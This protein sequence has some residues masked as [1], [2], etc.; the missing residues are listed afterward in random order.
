MNIDLVSIIV[1]VYNAEKYLKECIECLINQ[2]Y[3][4]IE[5][6]C[7]ND[8]SKDNSLEILEEYSKK[9]NRVKVYSQENKGEAATRNR[10][11]ELATG[12][13][14]T[15]VD[16]D[17]TCSLNSIE[18]CINIAKKTDS[19]VIAHFLNIRQNQINTPVNQISYLGATQLFV[20]KEL[21]DEHPDIRYNPKIKMGPDAV[22]SH[23]ILAVAKNISKN[24]DSVYFYRKHDE[25]ISGKIEN[26]TDKLLE[27]IKIWFEDLIDFYNQRDFWGSHNNHFMNFLCEQPF[28]SYLR[29]N[30]KKDQKQELFNLI[31]STIKKYNL[32]EKFDYSNNRVNMFKK[33]LK[34]KSAKDFEFWW[35]IS[36]YYIKY[37]DYKKRKSIAL[38][39][40]NGK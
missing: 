18:S 3:K 2:T 25:Q 30:W 38:G 6:I 28:T 15:S 1:P 31:H 14:I 11:L 8:G 7:I 10:G 23:K 32:K 40:M 21:I 33:F 17:D 20:K 4:N 39:G 12:K 16:S 24:T 36:H 9:D 27:N 19:D 5:I 26:Q 22:F 37:V 34:C 29:A 13:Y 35:L